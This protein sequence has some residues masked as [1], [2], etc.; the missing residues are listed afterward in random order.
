MTNVKKTVSPENAKHNVK[1][2]NNAIKAFK[3]V[4]SEFESAENDYQA[5]KYRIYNVL[6][7]VFEHYVAF[8]S[9]FDISDSKNK[10]A[11]GDLFEKKIQELGD[12]YSI[13]ATNATSL[14]LRMLR[15]VTGSAFKQEREKVYARCLRIA[16]AEKV[17]L[18]E[19]MSFADWII[20]RGG[21][22]EVRRDSE[23]KNSESEAAARI[24]YNSINASVQLPKSLANKFQSV[25]NGDA[26]FAVALVRK[27]EGAMTIVA[28]VDSKSA[29]T[30]TLKALGKGKSVED[31]QKAADEAR[32]KREAIADS[33]TQK[34]LNGGAGEGQAALEAATANINDEVKQEAV[35]NG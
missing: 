5:A 27:S 33:I 8:K 6:S 34:F 15:L 17:H 21:I 2:V 35:A 13:S 31:V 14:E 9:E 32:A 23:G 29:V 28:T 18:E 3:K 10:K 30:A 4:R 19:D 11:L 20:S 16:Y 22:E 26:D 24:E 1:I 25:S 12:E 7:V